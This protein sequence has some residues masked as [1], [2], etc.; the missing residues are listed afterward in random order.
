LFFGAE[1][2]K[3]PVDKSKQDKE[4]TSPYGYQAHLHEQEDGHMF[5]T[6]PCTLEAS[7]KRWLDVACAHAFEPRTPT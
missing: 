3:L 4:E 6:A 1:S 7:N 5:Q 2:E